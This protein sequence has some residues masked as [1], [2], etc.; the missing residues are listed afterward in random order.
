[1]LPERTSETVVFG[2]DSELHVMETRAGNKLQQVDA[3]EEP[4]VDAAFL[5]PGDQLATVHGTTVMRIWS[6]ETWRVLRSFD[7]GLG[8][9][10]C[11]AV[12]ADGLT[13]VCGTDNGRLI[14]FDV[15]G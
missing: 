3:A 11:L 15:D 10:T 9:L 4:F 12:A 8:G 13:G 2:W 6:A 14:L 1:L 5:G 7:W